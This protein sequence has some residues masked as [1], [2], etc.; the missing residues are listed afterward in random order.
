MRKTLKIF[1]IILLVLLLTSIASASSWSKYFGEIESSF[2][3][4]TQYHYETPYRYRDDYI[5]EE[6]KQYSQTIQE[7]YDNYYNNDYNPTKYVHSKYRNDA[8]YVNWK[9]DQHRYQYYSYDYRDTSPYY[10]NQYYP[11]YGNY[12]RTCYY[13][14]PFGSLFYTRCPY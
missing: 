13:N 6:E 7:H 10:Y 14:A 1:S 12:R 2:K 11:G 3:K 5:L 8:D 4:A 9:E